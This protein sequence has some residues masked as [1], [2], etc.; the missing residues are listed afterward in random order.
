[1][2]VP[3]S[4]DPSPY[5][6]I[7]SPHPWKDLEQYVS[8]LEFSDTNS[9]MGTSDFTT[10]CDTRSASRSIGIC[11]NNF[12]KQIVMIYDEENIVSF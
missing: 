1:M 3:K 10:S 2:P 12:N 5:F 9:Y 4:Q 11:L 8:I 6:I 7:A